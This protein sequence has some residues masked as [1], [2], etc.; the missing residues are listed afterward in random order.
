MVAAAPAPAPAETRPPS[1][2]ASAQQQRGYFSE[3]LQYGL[4]ERGRDVVHSTGDRGAEDAAARAR[5]DL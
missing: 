2:P 3:M 5:L 4:I 1:P